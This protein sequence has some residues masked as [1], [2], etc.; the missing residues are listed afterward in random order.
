M[1]SLSELWKERVYL[2]SS[3]SSSTDALSGHLKLGNWKSTLE[4]NDLVSRGEA[5]L[6]DRFAGQLPIDSP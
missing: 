4:A 2:Y 1:M 5:R 3:P 6:T